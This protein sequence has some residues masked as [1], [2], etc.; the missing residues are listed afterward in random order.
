M[1][2]CG[3]VSVE[4]VESVVK[5]PPRIQGFHGL[6]RV[7]TCCRSQPDNGMDAVDSMED[8][9]EME[10]LENRIDAQVLAR[11]KRQW[12]KNGRK[13]IPWEDL[14]KELGL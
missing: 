12:E 9:R 8:L 3:A 1:P 11:A 4:S 14:K 10:E 6:T 2:L 13:G 7:P 5:T